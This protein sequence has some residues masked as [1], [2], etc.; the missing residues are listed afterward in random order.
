MKRA[1]AVVAA[2]LLACGCAVGSP[3]P[4]AERRISIREEQNMPSAPDLSLLQR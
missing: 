4:T 3:D 1:V 2:A